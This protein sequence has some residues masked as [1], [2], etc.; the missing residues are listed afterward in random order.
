MLISEEK[1]SMDDRLQA[2]RVAGSGTVLLGPPIVCTVH[3]VRS[4][5][6]QLLVV[7][8][9]KASFYPSWTTL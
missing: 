5:P 6:S 4:V 1:A 9:S 2:V 8:P 3:V 7:Q